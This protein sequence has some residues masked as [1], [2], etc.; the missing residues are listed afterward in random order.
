MNFSLVMVYLVVKLQ[1]PNF[2]RIN[3]IISDGE[4]KSTISQTSDLWTSCR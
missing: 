3:Y 2:I 4:E 1:E